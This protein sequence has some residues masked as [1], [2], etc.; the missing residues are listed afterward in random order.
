ML[1]DIKDDILENIITEFEKYENKQK[2][3]N[4]LLKIGYFCVKPFQYV[5]FFIFMMLLLT[6]VINTATLVYVCKNKLN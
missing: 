1:E 4:V 6:L 2:L 3:Q 5:L